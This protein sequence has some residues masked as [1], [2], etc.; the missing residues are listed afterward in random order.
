MRVCFLHRFFLPYFLF[1]WKN[2][3]ALFLDCSPFLYRLLNQVVRSL[4]RFLCRYLAR[5]FLLFL[6]LELGFVPFSFASCQ[7]DLYSYSCLVYCLSFC[8]NFA[9]GFS[10]DIAKACNIKFK[11]RVNSSMTHTINE[12]DYYYTG[13]NDRVTKYMYMCNK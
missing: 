10:R 1:F 13:S 7:S 12:G 8:N 5:L 3:S 9:V 4:Y 11:G 2:F 6:S